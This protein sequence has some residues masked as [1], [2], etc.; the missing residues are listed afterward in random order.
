MCARR[1]VVVR[2]GSEPNK[3]SSFAD[4]DV[5]DCETNIAADY[6]SID[7]DGRWVD[8]MGDHT[9]KL[10]CRHTPPFHTHGSRFD[11]LVMPVLA[12]FLLASSTYA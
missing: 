1:S 6:C 7:E 12:P 8:C 11:G 3:K 4:V 5:D 9:W 10:V 2:D